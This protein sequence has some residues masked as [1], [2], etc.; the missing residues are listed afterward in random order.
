[1]RWKRLR[2]SAN[3]E[4]RRGSSRLGRGVKVGGGIGTLL[5]IV[6]GLFLGQDVTQ[7][8]G[9]LEGGIQT[10]APTEQDDENVQFVSAILASTEDV[11]SREFAV[12][13]ARY[14][15]PRLVLFSDSVDSACGFASAAVGPFYCPADYKIYIDLSFYRELERM[16]GAGDFA[17]AYVLGHEVGHH[18]QN[19]MGVSLAVQR[20]RQR[21]SK[22]EGNALSVRAELQADCYAGVWAHHAHENSRLLEKGDIEEGL[23]A[24]AAIGDDRL[25]KE[26][27]RVVRPDAFTHG[28]SEQRVTWFLT[29]LKTGRMESCDT[30][31]L[32]R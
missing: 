21:M 26:S 24:A 3:V 32:R 22:A 14:K 27:G 20:A 10:T 25:M 8:L 6:L 13:N 16:G 11:W 15:D 18:L 17:R 5:L 29:G 31:P 7:L 4:D 19:L 30:L 12:R 9:P 2:R 28:S 1:M 23:R